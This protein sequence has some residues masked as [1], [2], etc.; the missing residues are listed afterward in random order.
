MALSKAKR[1]LDLFKR[2][3]ERAMAHVMKERRQHG[4]LGTVPLDMTLF[5]LDDAN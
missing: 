4:D 1:T 3:T 2:V 5:S